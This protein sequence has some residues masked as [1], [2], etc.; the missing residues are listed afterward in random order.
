[1]AIIAAKSGWGI[2]SL[3]LQSFVTKGFAAVGYIIASPWKIGFAFDKNVAKLFFKTFGYATWLSGVFGL[4]LYHFMP[5]LI[6]IVSNSYQAG[7]YA[8][9]F[10]IATFP[11]SITDIFERLTTPLYSAYQKSMHDL[12]NVFMKTQAFK[13][14]LLVPIQ[15]CMGLMA[16]FWVP[17]VLGRQWIPMIP[18]YQILVIYGIFRAFFDD[19]PGL[20][21]YGFK[22]PWELTRNQIGQAVIIIV[23]GPVLVYTYQA[24]GGACAIALTMSLATIHFWMIVLKKLGSTPRDFIVSCINMPTVMKNISARS[25]QDNK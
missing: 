23:I 17:L 24:F 22:S 9:A 14:F 6:G 12:K 21:L 10:M 5:F 1:V 13:L 2:Y 4:M 25:F 3:V 11:L 15:I 18:I 20:L 7:L 16:S 8:K 19:V